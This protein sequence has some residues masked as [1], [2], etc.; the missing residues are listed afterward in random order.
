MFKSVKKNILIPYEK[1][2]KLVGSMNNPNQNDDLDGQCVSH[3]QHIELNR[4]KNTEY[5]IDI[6]KKDDEQI[7]RKLSLD[8][9]KGDG[10]ISI[11]GSEGLEEPSEKSHKSHYIGDNVP[12]GKR[13]KRGE[14]KR[15]KLGGGGKYM[16]NNRKKWTHF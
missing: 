10:E 3:T 4:D 14:G 9:K 6:D 7:K 1:Y 15:S 8:I 11:N 2:E 12:P 5:G 13:L 16:K